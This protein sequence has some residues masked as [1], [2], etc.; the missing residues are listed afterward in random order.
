MTSQTPNSEPSWRK[1]AGIGLILLIIA[2]W[3]WVATSVIG[4][5][6]D[7]PP[8]IAILLYAAAGIVW[9]LPLRPVLLWMETGRWRLDPDHHGPEQS[10]LG[11]SG[12][13]R[14][15]NGASDGT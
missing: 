4:W 5:L 6:G 9:I 2:V 1:P 12:K 13:A 14:K 7:L 10:S 8:L 11:H 3:A 15:G